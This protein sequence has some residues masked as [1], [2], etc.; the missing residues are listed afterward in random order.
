MKLLLTT[1]VSTFKHIVLFHFQWKFPLPLFFPLDLANHSLPPE[2]AHK[3]EHGFTVTDENR[4]LPDSALHLYC[5]SKA[6]LIG[7]LL[8]GL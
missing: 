1:K 3:S 7:N 2:G 4:W 6:F 5:P 8:S